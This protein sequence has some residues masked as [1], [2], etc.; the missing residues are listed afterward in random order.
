M[1]NAIGPDVSFYQDDPDTP[2]HIDFAK[3]KESADFVI[4]R[5]GQNLWPD[6]DFTR[7]WAE[8]KAA[9]LPRG[10]YWFYDSRADP[11]RQAELW[12]ES[13]GGDLGELPLFAD[14]EETYGGTYQGWRKWY[15]FLERLKELVGQKEI[16]IYTAFYYWRDNAPSATT[17][18]QSL[19]YFHQYPLWIANYGVSEPTI[20]KPWGANEWLFWQFTETG[21]GDLYGVES[22]GIDL[23]YFN[24][25]AEAFRQRFGISEPPPSGNEKYR[26]E[27]SIRK[28]PGADENVVGTLQQDE[29]LELL[30]R[31]ADESWMQ[32]KREDGTTG[33]IYKTHLIKVATTPPPPPPPPADKWYRVTTAI[34]NVRSGPG[35][36]YEDIGDL[37]QGDVV[38]ALDYALANSWI[39]IYHSS[40]DLT[41]WSAA[42]YLEETTTPPDPGDPPDPGNPPDSEWYRVTASTLNV[43]QGPSTSDTI[44][45]SLP[46]NSVVK[47]LEKNADGSWI[48]ILRD[49]DGLTGWCSASY[50]EPTDAPTEPPTVEAKNWYQVKAMTLNV[51]EGP[52]TSNNKI[53][54]LSQG[55]IVVELEA[56]DDGSWVR[57]QRFDGLVGWCAVSYLTDLGTTS[58]E[59]LT[60]RIFSGVTYFRK[61]METPRKMVA[62]VLAIDTHIAGLKCLVTPPSDESG[63]I[64]TRKTS[65]F[66][67]EFGVQVAVNGDGFQYLDQGTY[68]PGQYCP[69]GGEP[70][71]VNGYAA[72]R[73]TVYAPKVA[74]RPIMYI[75]K[76]NEVTFNAQKGAVYNAVSGDRMLVDKGKR[77]A[78]L[79][80]QSVEPRTAAGLNQNGRWLFLAVIDGRQPGYSLGATF[81]DLADFLISLG[82]YTGLNLDGGGSSAMVVESILGGPFVL[83]SPI[84]GNIPGNESAVSN[85]L[86]FWVNK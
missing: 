65:K 33:W 4:I 47:A 8:A 86:G 31:T 85:H 5:A 52:S 21:D 28:G 19:E 34:L 2:E 48:K 41:G 55:Q 22:N 78:N 61:R 53:G 14:F 51:R 69:N 73:G 1:G 37:H 77:V 36:N 25:D 9:G 83:N 46:F 68:P 20:P 32:V 16:A 44:I 13:M 45:G 26:V 17:D 10:T 66:L 24:G 76:S 7:N 11:K 64:C 39:K 30:D 82:V 75:N 23:D 50:L 62:H 57:I 27:L 71:K 81:P 70:V 54:T 74:D 42:A 3:M 80:S 29:V 18:P 59:Q 84:E 6:R 38:K 49:S 35:T 56:N 58:P 40:N 63:L 72:S 79:E 15:D 60:Q 12:V 67:E 43:R